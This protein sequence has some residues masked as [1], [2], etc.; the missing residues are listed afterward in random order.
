MKI[1]IDATSIVDG[2]GFTHLKELI[3]NYLNQKS[4]HQLIVYDSKNVL[5]QL[6]N[7]P[8]L[9]KHNFSFLNKSRLHRLFF[10][11]L[12]FDK[13]LKSECDVFISVT[14]DYFGSFR[15]YIAMSQ[16]MMLFEREFWREIKSIKEKSKFY[17]NFKR[18]KKCFKNAE[19]IIFLSQYAK[20]YISR[21]L[22]IENKNTSI[23]HH[24]ISPKF[25]SQKFHLKSIKDY[26][27]NNP[28]RFLYV[29][30]VHVYKNQW[31]VVAAISKLRQKGYPVAL[32]L[33][34]NVIYKPSGDRLTKVINQLDPDN[35]F[36]NHILKIPHDEIADQYSNHDGIIFA[37][38]C[39]NMPNILLESMAS[40]K[41][42]ACSNK[43]PMP[44]FLKDGG[45]YFNAKSVNSIFETLENLLNSLKKFEKLNK[46]NIHELK[47]YNWEETSTKTIDFIEKSYLNYKNASE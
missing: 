42:I 43:Q 36:I 10:Q 22:K 29:S 39:E 44:E 23:I 8:K 45:F 18:Q 7:H 26:S 13:Y 38:T 16:N 46:L 24:G 25:L 6:S 11:I 5:D 12:L 17:F 1:G 41:P 19:G 20:D 27:M 33:I 47:K 34:G 2:G 31:N 3:E 30:T 35:Q 14:G 4:N 15:P 21:T 32:T 40:G 9:S 37:S 28:F